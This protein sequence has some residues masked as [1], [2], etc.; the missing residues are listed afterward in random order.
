M[1]VVLSASPDHPNKVS[2]PSLTKPA[3]HSVPFW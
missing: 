3:R 2:P 1:R